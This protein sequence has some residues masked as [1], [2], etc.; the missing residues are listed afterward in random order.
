MIIVNQFE[1]DL[2]SK[3]N[4][5]HHI[6]RE[7]DHIDHITDHQI[8]INPLIQ[9]VAGKVGE[10]PRGDNLDCIVIELDLQPDP[11]SRPAKF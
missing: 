6:K 3:L 5:S 10:N 1:N 4:Q 2:D 7:R 11:Q 9:R 8:T